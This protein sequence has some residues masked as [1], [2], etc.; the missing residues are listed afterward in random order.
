M[1]FQEWCCLKKYLMDKGINGFKE[2]AIYALLPTLTKISR[3]ALFNGLRSIEALTTEE[4]GFQKHIATNWQAASGGAK[5]VIINAPV[6]WIPEYLG[7]DYLGIIINLIDDIAHSTVLIVESKRT[8][9]NSLADVLQDTEIDKIINEFLL[10]GYRVYIVSDHGSVWCRGN[11]YQAEKYLVEDHA[12]RALVYPNKILAEEFCKGKG[13]LQ[14]ENQNVS[15]NNV[16]VF[17]RS[18]DMFARTKDLMI[19]HGGIHIEEVI[20][21]FIEVAG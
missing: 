9:Q 12:K 4:N 8:M 3:R 18:R 1:G 5:K 2:S 21:P 13:L 15:G 19:T 7:Y 16:L 6:K 10:N 17:P 20:V 11:G 14:Y